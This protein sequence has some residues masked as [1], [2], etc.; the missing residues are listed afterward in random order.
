ML[1]GKVQYL[2]Y[3]RLYWGQFYDLN[4]ELDLHHIRSCFHGTFATG[5]AYQ[6][7][8]LTLVPSLLGLPYAPIVATIFLELA[9]SFLDAALY[10]FAVKIRVVDGLYIIKI[11]KS[12]IEHIFK[13]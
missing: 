12:I 5:V 11:S 9:V 7:G 4:T 2:L 8:T 1:S 10:R 3:F 13:V 6:Q